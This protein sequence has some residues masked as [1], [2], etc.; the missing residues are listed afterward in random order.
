MWKIQKETIVPNEESEDKKEEDK[1]EI[2]DE[3]VIKEV[4]E[5]VL[6]VVVKDGKK[7]KK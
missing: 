7:K 4:N 5:E 3:E 2:K 1:E 6:P